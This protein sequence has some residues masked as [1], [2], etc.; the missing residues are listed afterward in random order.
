M[1]LFLETMVKGP[2]S[3][4][5]VYN[6]SSPHKIDNPFRSY[7]TKLSLHFNRTLDHIQ[8]V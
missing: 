5:A 1:K 8:E 3:G 6:G 4:S 7:C 2:H